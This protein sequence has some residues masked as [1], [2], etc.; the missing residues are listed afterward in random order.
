MAI[1]IEA[2]VEPVKTNQYTQD[3]ADLIAAGPNQLG[4]ITV[5]KGEKVA[6]ARLAFQ[7]AAKAADR[8]AR[9]KSE[10]VTK[11]GATILGFLLFDK[12]KPWGSGKVKG[13]AAE[14]VEK[15]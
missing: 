14:A 6:A 7:N 9:V 13:E 4:K 8:S 2:Y 12:R 1:E 11:D 10:E 5:P 15:D 3:V